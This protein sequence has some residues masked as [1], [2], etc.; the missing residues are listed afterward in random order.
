M[1]FV[2]ISRSL[3]FLFP[4]FQIAASSSRFP[5]WPPLTLPDSCVGK[6]WKLLHG[7]ARRRRHRLRSDPRRGANA[8]AEPANGAFCR[9][10]LKSLVTS[11]GGGRDWWGSNLRSLS[12]FCLRSFKEEGIDWLGEFSTRRRVILHSYGWFGAAPEAERGGLMIR[13]R[14][15]LTLMQSKVLW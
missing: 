9:V 14:I 11:T 5:A 8:I 15:R 1:S 10:W 7:R 13:F 12:L 2:R 3:P 6:G 4:S